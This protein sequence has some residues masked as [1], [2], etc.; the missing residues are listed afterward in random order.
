MEEWRQS[1]PKNKEVKPN[2]EKPKKDGKD[3]M[4]GMSQCIVEHPA[5]PPEPDYPSGGCLLSSFCFDSPTA[6]F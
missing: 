1:W 5:M 3:R 6:T 4:E 2:K